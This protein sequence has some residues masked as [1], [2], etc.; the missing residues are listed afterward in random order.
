M[1]LGERER[2]VK[3]LRITTNARHFTV[4][5]RLDLSDVNHDEPTNLGK[6]VRSEGLGRGGYGENR[7]ESN[8]TL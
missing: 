4:A 7:L 3:W 1:Q 5:D 2:A 6:L 8:S